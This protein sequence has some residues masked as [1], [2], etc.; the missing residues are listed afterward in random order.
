MVNNFLATRLVLII[1]FRF[2][3]CS[4]TIYIRKKKIKPP[5]HN[6]VGHTEVRKHAL[7]AMATG[8]CAGNLL[9]PG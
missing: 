2:D 8:L 5:S 4:K 7:I 6:N 1:F 3:F 9:P